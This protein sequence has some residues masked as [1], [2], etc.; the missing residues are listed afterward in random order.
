[1]GE[2]AAEAPFDAVGGSET[3]A[4][5]EAEVPTA[6][7]ALTDSAEVVGLMGAMDQDAV[8]TAPSM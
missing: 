8:A 4:E 1:M 7:E 5:T 3:N 6:E 2:L